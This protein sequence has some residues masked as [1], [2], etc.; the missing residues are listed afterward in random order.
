MKRA[1][2]LLMGFCW[3]LTM[4]AQV[5]TY[6]E[7]KESG[8][9]LD[10]LTDAEIERTEKIVISGN[11]LMGNDFAVLKAMLVRYN[12]KEIDIENTGTH[13]ITERAFEGCSN[14]KAI[15]LPKYLVNTG[16]YSF[17]DCS[18]L[19]NVELPLSVEVIANSF[20]GCSSLTSITLGRRV[21]SLD[22]QSFYLCHNLR[23]VHCKGA[24]P[25]SCGQTSFEGLYETCILY[26]P[27]GC[28]NKYTFADG[29]LNFDNIRE[30]H[31]ESACSLQVDLQGGTFAWQLYPDYE[32]MGGAVV[33]WVYPEE[34]CV[35]EVEKNETVV[36]LIAEENTYFS[37]WQIESILLNGEDIISQLTENRLLYLT[38]NQDSKLEIRMKDLLATSIET[39]EEQSVDVHVSSEVLFIK[40]VTPGKLIRIYNISGNLVY[41]KRTESDSYE[42]LLPKGQIYLVQIGTKIFKIKI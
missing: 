18:G 17:Y 4:K 9:L 37:N 11:C 33:Q 35:I 7:M 25:P 15:K 3:C 31:V 42:V 13:T 22:S 6:V 19:T 36:F 2:L 39:I 30:E 24:I 34:E 28:K 40:N 14:L 5:V 41:S 27:E 29:W 10:L 1:L 23:E 20:R 21:K 38:I 16:W 8:S 12:L 32:G 26:V